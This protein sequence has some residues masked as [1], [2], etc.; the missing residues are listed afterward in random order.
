M[1]I[2]VV[3]SMYYMFDKYKPLFLK[4]SR[5]EELGY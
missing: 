3:A 4:H 2:R 5:A 1:C